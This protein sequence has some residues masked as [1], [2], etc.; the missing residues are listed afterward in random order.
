MV[1]A[2]LFAVEL[3]VDLAGNGSERTGGGRHPEIR[4]AG[5]EDDS[6]DL[7][8]STDTDLTV[9]LSIHVVVNLYLRP[10]RVELGWLELA[11]EALDVGLQEV[12]THEFL[13]RGLADL[14]DR[15]SHESNG[16]GKAKGQDDSDFHG[17]E[18]HFF[19]G[20]LFGDW[21]GFHQSIDRTSRFISVNSMDGPMGWVSLFYGWE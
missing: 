7:R 16:E 1:S 18:R 9:V 13:N 20:I 15:H 2:R 21:R 6:E 10:N 17:R 19:F 3:G 8:G 11:E 5:I 4:R 12:H 14:R